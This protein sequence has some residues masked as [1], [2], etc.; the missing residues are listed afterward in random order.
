MPIS[1]SHLEERGLHAAAREFR[2]MWETKISKLK[3]GYSSSAG[4]FSIPG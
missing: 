2:T 1:E 3:G 4:T